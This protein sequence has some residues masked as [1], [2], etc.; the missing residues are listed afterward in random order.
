MYMYKMRDPIKK[1]DTLKLVH[2]RY[3]DF[4]EILRRAPE[5]IDLFFG[6]ESKEVKPN[7][8]FYTFVPLSSTKITPAMGVAGDFL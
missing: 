3:E 5:C 2:K 1:A 6:L 4:P 7:S 8:N